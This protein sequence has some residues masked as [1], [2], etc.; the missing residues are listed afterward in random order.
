MSCPWFWLSSSLAGLGVVLCSAVTL[1]KPRPG[2]RLTVA[3]NA[4]LTDLGVDGSEPWSVLILADVQ[5]GFH[6]LPEIFQRE[7]PPDLRAVVCLGDLSADY[8]EAHMRLPV[9][10]L[11]ATPPPAPFFI[12]PGN[13]D[14][15]G[16]EGKNCFLRWFGATTFEFRMLPG[17][18]R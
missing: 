7:M 15:R 1:P 2:E 16:K 17:R 12:V 3:S 8:D 4:E 9:L 5:N 10:E 13:H 18:A 14:I 6:Y 11:L